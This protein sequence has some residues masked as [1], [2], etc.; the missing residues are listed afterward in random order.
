M[1]KRQSSPRISSL[2]AR[3]LAGYVP[4]EAEVKSLAASVLSQDEVKGGLDAA[5]ILY[6][7]TS[8]TGAKPA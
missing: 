8:E 2:A 5:E 7:E 3:V 6:G 1:T 4:T